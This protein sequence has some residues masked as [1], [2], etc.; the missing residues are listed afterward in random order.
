MLKLI[1]KISMKAVR[2]ALLYGIKGWATKHQN[3][4]NN[5]RR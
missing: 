4:Q 3:V 2:L 1:E 5:M